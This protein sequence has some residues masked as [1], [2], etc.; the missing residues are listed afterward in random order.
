MCF[1]AT[2]SFTAAAVLTPIGVG[3][4][5]YA[6]RRDPRVVLLAAF[7]LLFGTQQLLEGLVWLGIGGH[8]RVGA[9]AALGYLFFSHFLWLWWVPLS[10]SR[11]ELRG[12]RRALAQLTTLLGGAFGAALYAPLL[13][14][15][16]RLQVAVTCGSVEYRTALVFD[17]WLPRPVVHTLYAAIVT[18][19][20]I[21]QS[22]R[23]VR[24]LGAL[25]LV[26][27]VTARVGFAETFI[28][29]WCFLA[30]L[31]SASIVYV[32]WHRTRTD[33][34]AGGVKNP[35]SPAD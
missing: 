6:L 31:A 3:C 33:R 9:P 12:R 15:P 13:L 8:P 19:P 24:V 10:V 2:A 28:S 32:L 23:A 27:V 4:I 35:G 18:L 21:A 25:I 22:D 34:D 30:A 20:L 29:I 26:G 16:D 7:P 1:S 5:G 14:D 17:A 11:L